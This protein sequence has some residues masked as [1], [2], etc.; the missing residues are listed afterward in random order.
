MLTLRVC[1][2]ASVEVKERVVDGLLSVTGPQLFTH[3]RD[4]EKGEPSDV[5]RLCIDQTAAGLDMKRQSPGEEGEIY[6]CRFVWGEDSTVEEV[7]TEVTSLVSHRQFSSTRGAVEPSVSFLSVIRDGL[8]S[9]GGLFTLRKIPQVTASQ[10]RYL[11]TAPNLSYVEAARSLL[12]RLTDMS[13]KPH[14]LSK[15]ILEAYDPSRWNGLKDVCPLTPIHPRATS[16]ADAPENHS[17]WHNMYL[18]ELYHGPTGAFKDFALQL[19]PR[20]FDTAVA[21]VANQ[22]GGDNNGCGGGEVV[23]SS[24]AAGKPLQYMILTAT[25]GDT[26]VAA[27]S[28]FVNAK[29]PC[30][31]MVFYPLRGVSPVQKMHM[32][33][34][35]NGTTVRVI[36]VESDFDFCQQSVKKLFADEKLERELVNDAGVRLSSA[37]SINWGRLIPQVVYYFWA[38]RKCIQQNGDKVTEA[39]AFGDKVDFVVPSGNF[40]NI[41]AAYVAKLMGLP[42]G[43]LIVAS[44]TNDVLYEFVSTGCYDISHRHLVPTASPS[45]DILKASNVERFLFILSDGDSKYVSEQMGRLEFEK[46]FEVCGK[47]LQRMQETFWSSKCNESNCAAAIKKIFDA[48]GKLLDPH[49]AVALHAATEY[50]REHPETRRPLVIASTAHWAKFPAAVLHAILGEDAVGAE[51]VESVT[52]PAESCKYLYEKVLALCPGEAVHPSL[53]AVLAT[54]E[55]R[56]GSLKP[57][58]ATRDVSLLRKEVTGFVVCTSEGSC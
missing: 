51:G 18:L 36:G 41:L 42:V 20:Y 39:L 25:S 44:N 19:F 12:E 7:I 17:D 10:L 2:T 45:I 26:G 56:S 35:D 53:R 48:T 6:D 24:T 1:G 5:F 38:Y 54:V 33:S 9:D 21:A 55:A 22:K 23:S 11:C 13:L 34:Y 52:D 50:R 37:N 57:R 49:T 43:K 31:V 28:G 16:V 8:A 29:S 46:R 47:V 58:V 30:R 4:G 27:I 3:P 15:H 14:I 32:I 40:G